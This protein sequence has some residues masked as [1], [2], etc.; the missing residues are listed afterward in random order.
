VE[1]TAAL[2]EEAERKGLGE[3]DFAALLEAVEDRAGARL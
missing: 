1:E 3:R 2:L